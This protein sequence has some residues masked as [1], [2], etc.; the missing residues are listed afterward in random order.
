MIS[1]V[2][3]QFN[4]NFS[5][6]KY[7]EFLDDL[8]RKHPGEIDFRV[9][10]T[11]VFIPKYFT[12]CML[13]ACEAIVDIITDPNFKKLTQRAIPKEDNVANE[14][15]HTDFIAFDFGICENTNGILEPQL[16]EMQGFP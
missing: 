2:R 14:N 3:Q 7:Q 13:D 15:E 16:V 6:K 10:E 12:K 4:N 8:N 5:K 1:E 11:P 9:A